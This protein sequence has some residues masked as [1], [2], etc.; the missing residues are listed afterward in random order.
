MILSKNDPMDVDLRLYR[1]AILAGFFPS[2]EDLTNEILSDFLGNKRII[3]AGETAGPGRGWWGPPVGTHGAGS[4]GG[5]ISIENG[6]ALSGSTETEIQ[7]IAGA[8][9]AEHVSG[10]SV[11]VTEDDIPGIEENWNGAYIDGVITMKPDASSQTFVHELGHHVDQN[12]WPSVRTLEPSSVKQ[13][14]REFASLGTNG[15]KYG[16]SIYEMGN[17]SE[18]IA[19]LYRGWVNTKISGKGNAISQAKTEI[20]MIAGI[21]DGLF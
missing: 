6:G 18:Y 5:G 16:M 3:L 2:K 17:S 4:Q 19:G 13:Y 8:L 12:L 21:M 1:E 10:V 11:K 20:P 9:P 7:E 14:S 15:W